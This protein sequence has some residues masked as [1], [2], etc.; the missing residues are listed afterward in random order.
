[1]AIKRMTE[2][3]S[4][5]KTYKLY[6][7]GEFPRSESGRHFAVEGPKGAVVANASRASRKDLRNSVV[8]ARKAFGSW[9]ERTAYN[10]GQILYRMAEVCEA[11]GAELEKELRDSGSSSANARREVELVIDRLVYFAGWADKYTQLLGTVNP[12]A[13]PYYNFTVPEPTGVAGI[14]APDEPSLLGLVS[15]VAPAIVSGNTTVVV[16]SEK[17]PLPAIT[18]AECLATADLPGG[19]VNILTGYRNEL[20]PWLAAHMDVNLID[21]TGLEPGLEKPAIE[22][23]SENVKRVIRYDV[24]KGWSDEAPARSL[25]A[26]SDFMEL[27]T[28]WHPMGM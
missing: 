21:L 15:R 22:A 3:L 25:G 11:R 7:G 17:K 19:V 10:R 12:V 8:A 2:R 24:S 5:R 4:V 6:I 13:G 14:V 20:A 26:I 27:K 28:I 18:F 1:M 16:A 9:G 23:A